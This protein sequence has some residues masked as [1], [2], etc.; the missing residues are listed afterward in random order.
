MLRSIRSLFAVLVSIAAIFMPNIASA[1]VPQFKDHYQELVFLLNQSGTQPAVVYL[2]IP[3][4]GWPVHVQLVAVDPTT[5]SVQAVTSFT[6]VD[7]VSGNPFMTTP[8]QVAMGG[9]ASCEG[10]GPDAVVECVIGTSGQVVSVGYT[11]T[12]TSSQPHRMFVK[13]FNCNCVL[14]FCISM[15]Y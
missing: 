2:P 9:P 6:I 1:Q 8:P 12:G 5:I 4:T 11:D 13:L 10:N 7:S 14:Q 3:R 15:W